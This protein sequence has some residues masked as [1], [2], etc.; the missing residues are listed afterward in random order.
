MH[1]INESVKSDVRGLAPVIAIKLLAAL[2]R[3]HVMCHDHHHLSRGRR[4]RSWTTTTTG[5]YRS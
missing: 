3:A 4:S 5:A 2:A 1:G